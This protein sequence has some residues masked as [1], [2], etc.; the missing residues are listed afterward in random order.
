MIGQLK[1]IIKKSKT[2]IILYHI[3]DNWLTKRKFKAG[4]VEA[5]KGTTHS[6][7]DLSISLAYINE[8]FNDYL[9]YSD[10]SIDTLH[11]KKILEIGPGDNLGVALKF[12]I[13][14]AKKVISLDKF[15]SIRDTEQEANIY[16][17]LRENLNDNEKQIFDE[18]IKFDNKIEINSEKL[19]YVYG[20]GIEEA[21]NVL[22]PE[23]F[24]FI[25]SRAVFEHL[26]DTD[27]AFSIMDKLLVSGGYMLHKIDLRDHGLFTSGGL[28]PLT[29]LT[30]SDSIY[31]LMSYDSGKPNRKLINYYKEK[32]DEL[33]Y[34]TKILITHILGVKNEII[35]H[36]NKIEFGIDY[37]DKTN[38][39][40]SEIRMKLQDKFK[41][42]TDEELMV[43]GIFII[44]RKP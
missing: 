16:Q 18:I 7:K 25:I 40:L 13:A 21:E 8:V 10:I 15:F 44:A 2:F 23:S 14:G 37:S 34:D 39:L 29:F 9:K 42:I 17:A 36:K 32:L 4:K 35:P 1:K 28:H 41:N 22:E 24:D 43:S 6:N 5:N 3:L 27:I 12:L 30:I 19:S 38:S 20:T 26:Y 31:K 11:N 33:N